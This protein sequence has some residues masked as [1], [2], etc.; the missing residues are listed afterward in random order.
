MIEIVGVYE[1]SVIVVFIITDGPKNIYSLS[2]IASS[3]QEGATVGGIPVL[4][5][6]EYVLPEVSAEAA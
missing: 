6:K 4:D 1:G 5:T 2:E 3:I